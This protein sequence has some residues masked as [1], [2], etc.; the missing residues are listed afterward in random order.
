MKNRIRE[1]RQKIQITQVQLA[2]KVNVSR[3][4]IISIEGGKYIPSVTLSLKIA[5]ALKLKVDSLFMLEETD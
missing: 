5:C 1:E 4:T 3:Q 2:E